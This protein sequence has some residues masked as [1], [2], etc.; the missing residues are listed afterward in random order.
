MSAPWQISAWC[1]DDGDARWD[2]SVMHTEWNGE[3]L[4]EHCYI[5]AD[6]TCGECE[7]AGDSTDRCPHELGYRGLDF[8]RLPA[9]MAF[10]P[11]KENA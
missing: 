8:S 10:N 2:A 11:K 9:C 7:Y 3:A 5:S 1:T 6:L 4:A